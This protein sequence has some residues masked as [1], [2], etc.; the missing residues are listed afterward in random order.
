MPSSWMMK[1]TMLSKELDRQ[2]YQAPMHSRLCSSKHIGSWLVHRSV[3]GKVIPSRLRKSCPL[4]PNLFLLCVEAFTTLIQTA[5]QDNRIMGLK[6]SRRRPRKINLAKSAITFTPNMQVANTGK[7]QAVLGLGD[8]RPHDMYLGPPT[9]VGRNQ[10]QTFADINEKIWDR[11]KGWRQGLFL[12]GRTFVH[13]GQAQTTPLEAKKARLLFA[14]FRDVLL[15]EMHKSDGGNHVCSK[16]CSGQILPEDAKAI[17]LRERLLCAKNNAL[18]I[19]IAK[20][21]AL[22]VVQGLNLDFSLAANASILDDI[23]ALLSDVGCGSYQYVPRNGKRVAQALASL[24]TLVSG[25]P[26]G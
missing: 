23:E 6:C 7:S 19:S 26:L 4:P 12:C 22:R 5:K 24:A 17:D 3:Q 20:Y 1:F 18:Q 14:E 25:D 8:A 11:I 2:R 15:L 9:V 13:V 16:D 10:R 21:D